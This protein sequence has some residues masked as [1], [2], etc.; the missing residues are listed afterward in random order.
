MRLA[1][2]A[3][4]AGLLVAVALP[5]GLLVASLASDPG[6]LGAIEWGPLW[7]TVILALGTTAFA[8]G[9]GVP[10][11]VVF[12]RTDLPGARILRLLA[13]LPYVVPP[14]VAAIAMTPSSM[15]MTANVAGSKAGTS[16]SSPRIRP[17]SAKAPARPSMPAWQ[18]AHLLRNTFASPPGWRSTSRRMR[19]SGIVV[20]DICSM[21]LQRKVMKL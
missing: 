2:A 16:N 21:S 12:G 3:A 5:L 20:S 13:T 10:L 18:P 9:C 15:A 6:A 14:Y 8:I 7:N 4:V 17:P 1:L 19:K 11:G